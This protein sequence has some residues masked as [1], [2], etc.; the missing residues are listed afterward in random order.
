M[1]A[2]NLQFE[3]AV[4]KENA[5]SLLHVFRKMMVRGGEGV[6]IANDRTG[7]DRHITSGLE[8]NRWG[9]QFT[10]PDLRSLKILND[11]DRLSRGL[12]ARANEPESPDVFGICAV[13]EV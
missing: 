11:A 9:F 12:G 8:F 4:V 10:D 3:L 2:E 6:G 13:R 7:R 1:G 5:V